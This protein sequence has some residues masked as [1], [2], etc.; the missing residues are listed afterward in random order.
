MS[1]EPLFRGE[2]A[3][4]LS[5]QVAQRFLL[6]MI[7]WNAFLPY[8]STPWT[9]PLIFSWISPNQ[10]R[11]F[12]CIVKLSEEF[13]DLSTLKHPCCPYLHPTLISEPCK[14]QMCCSDK[15]LMHDCLKG[16]M[17]QDQEGLEHT[18]DCSRP[19]KKHQWQQAESLR[20]FPRKL[21]PCIFDGAHLWRA[22]FF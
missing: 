13:A 9:R 3:S 2:A 8:Q 20:K 15:G 5:V 17:S 6:Q 4:S 7:L 21:L 1:Q 11:P 14:G 22:C 16:T 19:A 18:A 12:L 10:K